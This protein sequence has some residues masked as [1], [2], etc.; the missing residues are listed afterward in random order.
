MRRTARRFGR[1]E[2]TTATRNDMISR[3]DRWHREE[4]VALVSKMLQFTIDQQLSQDVATIGPLF[5]EAFE[6]LNSGT[7]TVREIAVQRLGGIAGN[8]S[9][10]PL[11]ESNNGFAE[12]RLF[13]SQGGN[14]Q[15]AD[16]LAPSH[17]PSPPF[18]NGL[19]VILQVED[20]GFTSAQANLN[21]A[22]RLGVHAYFDEE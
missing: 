9:A 11:T 20:L 13:W 4:T 7:V 15:E 5:G 14:L 1:D 19:A 16:F 8:N 21:V 17:V 22:R 2:V 18:A 10:I 12:L 6:F 3:E